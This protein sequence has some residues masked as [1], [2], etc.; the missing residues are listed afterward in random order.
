MAR[1]WKAIQPQRQERR[2]AAAADEALPLRALY[3][4]RLYRL[5]LLDARP[6]LT[7]EQRRL[8]NHALD[9]TYRDCASVGARTQARAMLGLPRSR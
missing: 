5:V 1:W 8:V 9:A 6:M 3:L 7:A 4:R 2:E